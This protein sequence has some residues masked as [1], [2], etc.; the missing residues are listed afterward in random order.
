M[1]LTRERVALS[2]LESIGHLINFAEY[3]LLFPF[4]AV[5]FEAICTSSQ[6]MDTQ[7][8]HFVSMPR[9]HAQVE[10]S[11]FQ[12]HLLHGSLALSNSVVILTSRYA[13]ILT[14]RGF[15]H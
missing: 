1:C 3:S 13:F 8:P 7:D 11:H 4:A 15:G 9:C 5:S 14:F 6:G 10:S 2:W 12:H